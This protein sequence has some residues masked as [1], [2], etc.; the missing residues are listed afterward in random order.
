MTL[1]TARRHLTGMALLGIGLGLMVLAG[2]SRQ[3]ASGD[4]SQVA[5]RVNDD[6]ISV[7][8]IQAVLQREPQ[9]VRD[10][11]EAAGQKALE[12]LVQ[13]EL[14][15]Q[16]A[17]SEGLD[18]APATLQALELAKREVLA[19]AYQDK[20]AAQVGAPA[21]ADIERYYDEHPKLFAQRQQYT[22]QEIVVEGEAPA[23]ADLD[24]RVKATASATDAL[25]AV[26]GTGLNFVSR[27]A[28]RYAEE[29]PPASLERVGA[30]QAGQ[31]VLVPR[32]GGATILT[33]VHA[34]PAPVDRHFARAS[35][36][37]ALQLERR[38]A[39]LAQSM[40]GLAGKAN[41]RY[42]GVYAHLSAPAE[43]ASAQ[44]SSPAP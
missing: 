1:F 2:C 5:A 6:E 41:V 29:L 43:G 35:I 42:E 37:N 11:G 30:M 22:L 27:Q 44:A 18:N 14:A 16:A 23:L 21:T 12:S 3:H 26:Q 20:I 40:R 15:A 13:Q 32:Q 36:S 9:L 31:S 19:R 7:H 8:Q 10:Y 39:L 25:R 4:R 17:R 28:I 33:L 38:R 24:A 34:D